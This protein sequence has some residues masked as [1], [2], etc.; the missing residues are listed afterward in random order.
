M[1]KRKKIIVFVSAAVLTFSNGG[2]AGEETFGDYSYDAAK[3]FGRGLVNIVSSLAEV[4]CTMKSDIQEK[5]GIGAATGL[6]TGLWYTVR[7]MLV[8]T[9]EV[10][11]FFLPA[12]PVLS[13]VCQTKTPAGIH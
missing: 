3:Q 1:K 9:T 13:P 4:P 2:Y 6:G 5:G 7:R 11:T 10:V 12:P 8:G